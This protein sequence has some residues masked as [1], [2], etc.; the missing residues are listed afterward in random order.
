MTIEI[1]VNS[2]YKDFY[3]EKELSELIKKMQ[4]PDERMYVLFT[5]CH[6]SSILEFCIKYKINLKKLKSYYETFI[7]NNYRNHELEEF[8]HLNLNSKY[9]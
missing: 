8:F 6:L 3:T 2:S 4:F 9:D 7:K 5:E 1:T